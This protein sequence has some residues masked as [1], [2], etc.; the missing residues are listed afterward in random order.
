[1]LIQCTSCGTQAK[2][3]DS[4][5]GAKVKCPS[6]GHVYVARRAGARGR[7]KKEE[8]P[9][10]YVI[11]GGALLAA[12]AVGI[13]ASRSGGDEVEAAPKE[14]VVEEAKA[15]RVD[16]EAWN[17]PLA[18]MVRDLHTAGAS[19]NNGRLLSTLDAPSAYAF[20][21]DAPQPPKP[22]A[23]AAK[24]DGEEAAPNDTADAAAAGPRPE[25]LALNE[26]ARIEF[27]NELIA[28]ATNRG[29]DGRVA[30]WTPYDFESIDVDEFAGTA[31]IVMKSTCSDPAVT[32]DGYTEWRLKAKLVGG[33]AQD[34]KWIWVDRYYTQRERDAISR[35][36]RKRPQKKTLSDGS[37]VY[38]STI[39]P[40]PFDAT[41]PAADQE[42]I[43]QLVA[44]LADPDLTGRGLTKVRD[45]IAL[46]GKNAV[47][48]LL[49]KMANIIG[50]AGS[51]S[52][53]TMEHGVALQV[54]H[55]S[56]RE[57]TGFE[58]TFEANVALG[59]TPERIESGAKQWFAWYDK[60]YKR[61]QGASKPDAVDAD[62]IFLDDPDYKP[63][64]DR[65]RA[66]LEKA[67]RERAKREKNKNN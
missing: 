62:S 3:P 16:L 42:R 2:I 35:G 13:M 39:R 47:P 30:L 63:T 8:D 54:I 36:P 10:K 44:D 45:A 19:G 52:E 20:F 27:S 6:C 64:T 48:A 25:W 57:V 61:F 53:F 40:I 46:E 32:G 51:M 34:W 60:K 55:D 14:E 65:E 7:S 41:V 26:L 22:P 66:L 17:G 21:P 29:E 56:L 58:T 50:E 24:A 43:T 11:I 18:Q 12:A 28:R 5:E 37:V 33:E 1:M 49:T 4:K 59:A 15:P 23:G 38:E 31:R 9:T 67:K